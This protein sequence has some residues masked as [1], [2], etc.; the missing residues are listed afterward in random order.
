MA[1]KTPILIIAGLSG[2]A[3]VTGMTSALIQSQAPPAPSSGVTASPAK[4]SAPVKTKPTPVA[5]APQS[6]QSAL[7]SATPAPSPAVPATDPPTAPKATSRDMESCKVTMAKVD[8]PNPPLN[9]RSLPGASG[10]S[11]VVG[12]L[13]NGTFVTIVDEKSNW[14]QISTPLKGW[15]TKIN[16]ANNCNEKVE[17]VE[18]ATG[19]TSALIADYFIGTGT[20]SYRL[21]LG[22]GQTLTVTSDKG[23]L[24]AIVAPDGQFLSGMND[25]QATWSRQLATTG[26]YT[27][28]MESNFKGYKYAFSVKVQ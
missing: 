8:D 10:D 17:R 4:S 22:Q 25:Q 18:F 7:P 5:I 2:L 15:V 26:D 1:P 20:H 13:K 23:P 3:A 21:N 9:V 27:L 12:Q 24:P 19:S 14:F 16:T 6:P 11:N 28:Q